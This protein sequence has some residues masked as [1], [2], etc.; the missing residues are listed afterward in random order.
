MV[1]DRLRVALVAAVPAWAMLSVGLL[2]TDDVIY[3]TKA[4]VPED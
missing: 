3:L 2:S 1:Q 4:A